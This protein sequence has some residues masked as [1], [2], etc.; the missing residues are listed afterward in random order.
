MPPSPPY[1]DNSLF[2]TFQLLDNDYRIIF[3]FAGQLEKREKMLAWLNKDRK[4]LDKLVIDEMN[5]S[6]DQL[7]VEVCLK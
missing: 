3:D 7:I 5:Y 1:T 2:I 6:S 4:Q